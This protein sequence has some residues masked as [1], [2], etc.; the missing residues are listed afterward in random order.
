MRDKNLTVKYIVYTD[1]GHGFVRPENNL[2]FYGH[3]DEFL[4]QYLGG[5]VEPYKKIEGASGEIR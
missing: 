4:G 3:T 5:R 1:E 2:D